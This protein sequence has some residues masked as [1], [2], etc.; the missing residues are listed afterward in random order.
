RAAAVTGNRK[1]A[2]GLRAPRE[3][4]VVEA[5]ADVAGH[6]GNRRKRVL[7]SRHG[8]SLG[9]AAIL[10]CAMGSKAGRTA[11]AQAGACPA[12]SRQ[13]AVGRCLYCFS[14]RLLLEL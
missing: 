4:F 7:I 9:G 6:Q 11:S 2:P 1:L 3:G 5:E 14:G 10:G 13:A 8:G 12:C